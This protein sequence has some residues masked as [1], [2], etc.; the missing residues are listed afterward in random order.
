[1]HTASSPV[2]A[3]H[4]TSHHTHG[5][6]T[7]GDANGDNANGDNANGDNAN[8]DGVVVIV[9]EDDITCNPMDDPTS[10]FVV[11]CTSQRARKDAQP[12]DTLYSETDERLGIGGG[13]KGVFKYVRNAD[14]TPVAVKVI[15][16]SAKDAER[17]RVQQKRE[18]QLLR[19][20]PKHP[21]IVQVRGV[22][23]EAR[24]SYIVMPYF[25]RDVVQ[26][27]CD[28]ILAKQTHVYDADEVMPQL[29][30]AVDFLHQEHNI[31]HRDIKAENVLFNKRTKQVT[32]I[33]FGLAKHGDVERCTTHLGTPSYVA[34][35][36]LDR[37]K[38]YDGRRVDAWSLGVLLYVL[39]TGEPPFYGNTQQ[40]KGAIRSGTY[41]V[42]KLYEKQAS[43]KS[44]RC[45][46]ELIRVAPDQRAHLA[47]VLQNVYNTTSVL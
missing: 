17:D 35:E 14:G 47:D 16:H 45:I 28:I 22:F 24:Q 6:D 37:V 13:S 9:H 15:R 11:V 7:N 30:S 41:P 43:S 39:C 25:P 19:K 33:D 29:L 27:L 40:R 12:F 18:L 10:D 32:L 26:D 46:A 23:R 42:Q 8:D 36:V 4:H 21:N 2:E 38:V 3:S 1:M 20:L 34:P 5:R 31:A 44:V